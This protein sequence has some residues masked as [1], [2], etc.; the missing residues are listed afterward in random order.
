M[1]PPSLPLGG[2]PARVGR[3]CWSRAWGFSLGWGNGI[4]APSDYD[5]GWARDFL[6][7]HRT[8]EMA[9]ID[10][11]ILRSRALDGDSEAQFELAH[12]YAEGTGVR[13]S[14]STAFRWFDRA[15]KTGHLEAMAAMAR[16]F[17]FGLGT[18]EDDHQALFWYEK[19]LA[20][21]SDDVHSDLGQLL[22][23]EDSTVR[24][25]P[26]AIEVLKEGWERFEDPVCAG[27]LA[28]VYEDEL[29]DEAGS[30]EWA[31]TAAEA[32]DSAAMVT[33]GYRHRFG[34][35]VPLDLKEMLRWYRRSAAL[36]DATALANLAICYQNGEGVTQNSEKAHALRVQA[37]D[38]GH[39]GSKIWLAFAWIDGTGCEKD[40]DRG[41]AELEELSATDAEVAHDLADRLIDGPGLERDIPA[42][43]RWMRQAADSGYSPAMTYLGTLYWY[44]RHVDL[45]RARA[46][47]LYTQALNLGDPHSSA[48]L[49]FAYFEGAEVKKD[50]ERAIRLL[51][52]AAEAGH[53]DAALW[54]AVRYLNGKEGLP[55]DDAE[56]V[57]LLEECSTKEEDGDALFTLAELVRDGRGTK[58]NLERALELFELASING[59]DTRVERATIR[60]ALRAG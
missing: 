59:R 57:R 15:A 21:G 18:D 38:L 12:C 23:E 35:G 4:R 46:V 17:D 54:L 56:A 26:R 19:A 29:G 50:S 10:V 13:E 42:G 27:V 16:C 48:N 6:D 58:K 53:A 1:K 45:D 24:N 36:G 14:A 9:D 33:L 30:L 5:I 55:R 7:P 37:A 43:L 3:L 2:G 41:R 47:E 20:A 60:R 32:G 31:R 28:E 51:T 11:A 25:V 8:R 40:P 49:G 22:C 34:D 44:G 39:M 52:A